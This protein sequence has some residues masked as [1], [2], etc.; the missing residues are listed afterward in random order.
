MINGEKSKR[1]CYIVAT[2]DG[3]LPAVPTSRYADANKQLPICRKYKPEEAWSIFEVLQ[4]VRIENGIEKA[5][6]ISIHGESKQFTE[7]L[8]AELAARHEFKNIPE[9]LRIV[10]SVA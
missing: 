7:K 10:G 5:R 3:K 4:W 1:V 6:W 2:E 8:L 9:A